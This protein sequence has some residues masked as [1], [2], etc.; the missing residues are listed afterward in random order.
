MPRKDKA[1][2]KLY[3]GLLRLEGRINGITGFKYRGERFE[4]PTSASERA[5][6]QAALRPMDF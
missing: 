2:I 1:V 3:A 6:N 4:P 5:A